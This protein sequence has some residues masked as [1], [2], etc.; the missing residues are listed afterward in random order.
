MVPRHQ[1]EQ[2]RI[3]RP[4]RVVDHF[5]QHHPRIRREA[6]HGA[7]DEGDAERRIGSGLDDVALFDVVALVQDDRDAVAD[8]GRGAGELGDVADHLADAR[9]AIGLRELSMAGQRV[10]D[11]AGE[12]GAIGRGQ[13]GALLALEVVMQHEFVVVLGQDQIDAGPLEVA[14]EQ[15]MRIRDDNGVRRRM[16][17]TRYR[18]AGGRGNADP[19]RQPT[20][21]RRI[22]RRNSKGATEKG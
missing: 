16:R 22:C 4:V 5:V 7:V 14:V 11:I 8:R 17:D 10:D 9:A 6:E 12:M 21:W 19:C 1:A 20:S 18:R 3:V 2:R 15:Q 13:R